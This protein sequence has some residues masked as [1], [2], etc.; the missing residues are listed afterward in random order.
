MVMDIIDSLKREFKVDN[1]KDLCYRVV[2]GRIWYLGF[3]HTFLKICCGIPICGAGDPTKA[4]Q[5]RT[6]PL[7]VFHSSDDPTVPVAGSRDMV[8]AINALGV[9]DRG[10]FLY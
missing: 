8:N 4:S 3:N 6:L 7:R 9:N 5:I 1:N 10:R 2:Y